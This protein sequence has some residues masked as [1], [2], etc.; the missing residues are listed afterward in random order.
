MKHHN[1]FLT[2]GIILVIL[3]CSSY[4]Y[5]FRIDRDK[6]IAQQ[7]ADKAYTESLLIEQATI[8]SVY[9]SLPLDVLNE[10]YWQIG[11]HAPKR[12]VVD[13]YLSNQDYYNNLD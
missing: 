10:V 9:K 4:A 6:A 1:L 2:L 8:D 5:T 11:D 3:L 12:Y 13:E 7:E